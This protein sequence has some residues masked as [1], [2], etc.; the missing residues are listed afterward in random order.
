MKLKDNTTFFKVCFDSMQVG[1]VVFNSNKEIVLANTPLINIFK[2]SSKEIYEKNIETLFSSS[3]LLNEFIKND[4][5]AKFK[6]QIET[7]GLKKNGIEIPIEV[8]FGKIEFDNKPYYKVLISDISVRKKIELKKDILNSKLEE[9]VKLRNIELENVIEK[10]KIS[11]NKEKDLNTLKTQFISL[12]S[13]EFK[14]PLS[15]ILSST[16]LMVKYADL[17]RI[18]KRDEHF[19]KVKSKIILLDNMINN[20]LT[21]ENIESGNINPSYSEFK[22]SNLVKDIINSTKPFLK[23]HQNIISLNNTSDIMH[24]DSKIVKIILT[25][26]L[27]NAIK[28]SEKDIYIRIDADSTNIYFEIEDRGIGIPENEQNLIFQRLFR[29]KNAVYYPGTGIG[30]NI[31]KGYVEKLKGTIDFESTERKGTT[32][33]IALPKVSC[34]VDN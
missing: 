9:E 10:L 6:S 33:K 23:K 8:S 18:D 21:L 24:Q 22:F 14:T 7:F 1:I 4:K 2:Y 28:Y 15:A 19:L 17:G 29:A 34:D 30:L 27:Y 32:F 25:N 13:H 26:L 31:V 20:L 16:E 11:L 12:A 5:A 3:K